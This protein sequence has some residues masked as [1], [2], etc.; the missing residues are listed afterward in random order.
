MSTC[1]VISVMHT[2]REHRYIT[3]WAPD[4]CGYRWRLSSAGRYPRERVMSKLG[5]YNSGCSNIAVSSEIVEALARPGNPR[6]FD[7]VTLDMPVSELLAVPNTKEAWQKLLANVVAP[8]Q[9]NS[10]PEF[11]GARRKK[12]AA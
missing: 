10:Y 1:I 7:G 5:Y 12:E 3:L 2:L 4:D 9:H 11:P 8:T 6:D